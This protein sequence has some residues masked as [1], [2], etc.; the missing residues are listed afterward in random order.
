LRQPPENACLAARR[1]EKKSSSAAERKFS[2][3]FGPDGA[4]GAAPIEGSGMM[5]RTTLRTL[6]ICS[7]LAG[8]FAGTGLAPASADLRSQLQEVRDR[9]DWCV[10]RE[11]NVAKDYAAH[12]DPTDDAGWA[13]SKK[14]LNTDYKSEQLCD[15]QDDYVNAYLASWQAQTLHHDGEDWK[16]KMDLAN[17]LFNQCVT[18]N[19]GKDRGTECA[20]ALKAN[21]QR[22][23]AWGSPAPQ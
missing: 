10:N 14:A 7:L 11:T 6:A 13:A 18:Q 12:S 22:A 17:S 8:L 5:N 20:A 15:G 23:T 21:A 19:A 9:R 2:I 1:E 3:V 16:A 4:R